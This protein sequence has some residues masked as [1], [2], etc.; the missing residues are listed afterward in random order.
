M[1]IRGKMGPPRWSCHPLCRRGIRYPSCCNDSRQPGL[2]LHVET[3]GARDYWFRSSSPRI[4]SHG[5]R[6]IR[7]TKPGPTRLSTSRKNSLQLHR[8]SGTEESNP[9]P[10]RLAR[11]PCNA[12]RDT[13][14]AKRCGPGHNEHL[15]PLGLSSP[16]SGS[17]ENCTCDYQGIICSSREFPGKR[18]GSLLGSLPR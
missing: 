1:A 8:I 9:D 11:T 13:T 12:V 3:T 6:K 15:P 16:P 7:K 18:H 4:R 17:R 14:P 5:L 10:P 2:V